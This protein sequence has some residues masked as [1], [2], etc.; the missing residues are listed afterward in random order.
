M[1]DR[2]TKTRK[3]AKRKGEKRTWEK[4]EARQDKGWRE[5][6][7]KRGKTENKRENKMP[8]FA[9][10]DLEHCLQ[11]QVSCVCNYKGPCTGQRSKIKVVTLTVLVSSLYCQNCVCANFNCMCV[12]V[13]DRTFKQNC[14]KAGDSASTIVCEYILIHDWRHRVHSCMNIL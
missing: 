11:N 7:E 5:Q 10:E 9:E 1:W 6:R 4:W 13:L 3:T 14:I 8:K 2:L 12:N